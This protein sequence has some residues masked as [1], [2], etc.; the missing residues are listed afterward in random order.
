VA[1]DAPVPDVASRLPVS[2]ADPDQLAA[3]EA[4]WGLGSSLR[5]AANVLTA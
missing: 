5:R 4:R 2:D 1:T 3:L